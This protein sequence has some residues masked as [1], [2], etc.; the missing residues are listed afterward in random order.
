MFVLYV[1]NVQDRARFEIPYSP[2]SDIQCMY[3]VFIIKL[4]FIFS[5]IH[6]FP[7]F[8]YILYTDNYLYCSETLPYHLTGEGAYFFQDQQY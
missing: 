4:Q 6:I 3:S 5:Q 8:Y 1:S 7:L 2:H